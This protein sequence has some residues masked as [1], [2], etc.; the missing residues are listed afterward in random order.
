MGVIGTG[1]HCLALAG[2]G[3]QLLPIVHGIDHGIAVLTTSAAFQYHVVRVKRFM[4]SVI[5]HILRRLFHLQ[6][7]RSNSLPGIRWSVTLLQQTLG[8]SSRVFSRKVAI[9]SR[10]RSEVRL[11]RTIRDASPDSC[12]GG[13]L[14]LSRFPARVFCNTEHGSFVREAE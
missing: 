4:V 6:L 14:V 7:I 3:K 12:A 8:M 9:Y 1:R 5:A 11:N 10:S 2:I 13:V